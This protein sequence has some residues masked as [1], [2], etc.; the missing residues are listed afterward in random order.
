MEGFPWIA[1]EGEEE[2][3]TG[4][5]NQQRGREEGAGQEGVMEREIS[6]QEERE[7]AVEEE[8]GVVEGKE[9]EAEGKDEEGKGWRR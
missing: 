1:L 2:V 7:G 8:E 9:E 3:I 4:R 5:Q 6:E